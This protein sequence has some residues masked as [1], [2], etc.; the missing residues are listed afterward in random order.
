MATPYDILG[1]KSNCTQQDIKTAFRR[2]AK[3]IHP[4]TSA[5]AKDEAEEEFKALNVA[6]GWLVEHHVGLVFE[7]QSSGFAPDEHQQSALELFSSNCTAKLSLL[8]GKAG[9]GKSS[10]TAK[11]IEELLRA[12]INAYKI[13]VMSPTGKAAVVINKMMSE[14]FVGHIPITPACTIHRGFGCRGPG[15][16]AYGPDAKL[17]IDVLVLDE[18]S[19]VDSSLLNRV[20][21]A[22]PEHCRVILVGD[23]GQLLPVGAGCPFSDIVLYGN[24]NL[25]KRLVVNYRQKKGFLLAHSAELVSNGK[26]PLFGKRGTDTLGKGQDDNIFLTE[27]SEPQDIPEQVYLKVK[28]WHRN[29][30]DYC[31][32]SP[33]WKA[34][35][36]V[37][38]INEYLQEKLNPPA[39]GK[40]SIKLIF[41]E[42]RVGDRVK[43]TKNDY[44]IGDGVFNG[45]IGT[46]ISVSPQEIVVDFF[47]K[48]YRYNR[49]K[50]NNLRLGYCVTVHASQGS[51]YKHVCVVIHSTHSFTLTKQLLYVAFSRATSSLEVVGNMKG[52]KTGVKKDAV[53]ERDTGLSLDLQGGY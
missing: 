20:L 29:G 8:I 23:H 7:T 36:G 47:D 31:V 46:V 16:W 9:R 5:K 6:Y 42:L 3:D 51:E 10:V 35:A 1:V 11:G 43:Q 25:A 30:E 14:Y 34:K 53:E 37:D 15:M 39:T 49:E 26:V 19:M 48:E 24:Q 52:I 40:D 12:G 33:Q 4:D 21:S 22:L 44:S 18:A 41:G 32:M 38:R 28:E 17:D 50:A 27:V 13:R 2:L 45:F